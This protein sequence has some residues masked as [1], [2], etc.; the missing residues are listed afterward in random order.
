MNSKLW[1]RGIRGAAPVSDN[2][3]QA[4]WQATRELLTVIVDKNRLEPDRIISIIFSL[5]PD[6]NAAFPAAAVRELGWV[7]VP[8][9]GT[10]EADVPG[11]IQK[12]VRVLMHAYLPCSQEEVKHIYLKEAAALR[13]DLALNLALKNS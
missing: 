12:C 13:P 2:T 7:H 5:T 11:A 3:S 10:T 4:I 6:L 8:L 1:V 9:F